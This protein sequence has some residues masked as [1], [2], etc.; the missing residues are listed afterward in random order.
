MTDKDNKQ[1]KQLLATNQVLAAKVKEA[2]DNFEKY[3]GFTTLDKI[4]KIYDADISKYIKALN[5]IKNK[6][7][8]DFKNM[9]IFI[10]HFQL[11]RKIV[12]TIIGSPLIDGKYIYI[13]KFVLDEVEKRGII[14][15]LNHRNL[16]YKSG[17]TFTCGN[18]YYLSATAAEKLINSKDAYNTNSSFYTKKQHK[19][20]DKYYFKYNNKKAEEVSKKEIS[21]QDICHTNPVYKEI[22]QQNTQPATSSQPTIVKPATIVKKEIVK[23][24]IMKKNNDI[25]DEQDVLSS[26]SVIVQTNL[27]QYLQE[28]IDKGY[29]TK[30]FGKRMWSYIYHN[31]NVNLEMP[32][33]GHDDNHS[34]DKEETINRYKVLVWFY[35]NYKQ[36][37]S[38]KDIEKFKEKEFKVINGN[39]RTYD[40]DVQT[41]I[42]EILK[43][44]QA[45][46]NKVV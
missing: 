40:V 4:H 42:I 7:E 23:K 25:I 13:T 37:L 44:M 15:C 5:V 32:S 24:E 43:E 18:C 28:Y 14:K 33:T 30:K 31:E 36:Y 6:S 2:I 16:N 21:Q 27:R 17:K 29:I 12:Q 19:L 10:Y 11:E 34:C 9:N 39:L 3:I 41:L 35:Y 8:N 45:N 22:S 20:I 26:D 1:I 38:E 46:N